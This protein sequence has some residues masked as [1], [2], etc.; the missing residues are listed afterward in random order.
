MGDEQ[1]DLP[2]ED[3]PETQE[4]PP[5]QPE[6]N[7]KAKYD[8]LQGA[9][10]QLQTQHQEL[11]VH[12][13]DL[14]TQ[15]ES[16][17]SEA[18]VEIDRLSTELQTAQSQVEQLTGRNQTLEKQAEVR[19]HIA[20]KYPDL[21]GLY[22]KGLLLGVDDLE[23]DALDEH[24]GRFQEEFGSMQQRDM[25]DHVAGST[26]APQGGNEQTPAKTADEM[27]DQLMGMPPGTEEYNKLFQQYTQALHEQRT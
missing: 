8:G 22:D 17:T 1:I 5:T 2:E 19:R 20:S 26:P 3:A 21:A 13:V 25:E 15:H 12:F 9:F 10:K 16:A 27:Y 24:L 4:A 6:T 14:S 18:Q 7:W 23:G 11:K